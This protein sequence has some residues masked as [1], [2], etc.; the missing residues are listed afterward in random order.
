MA[1]RSELPS[2][3]GQAAGR[4]WVRVFTV[5]STAALAVGCGDG[6]N[7]P[8]KFGAV[9][10]TVYLPFE[11]SAALK[12]AVGATVRLS[13]GDFDTSTVTGDAG[14]FFFDQVPARTVRLVASLGTCLADTQVAVRVTEGDTTAADVTLSSSPSSNCFGLPF[15]GAAR[16]E[17]DPASNRAVLLYDAAYTS[18]DRSHPAIVVVD[19]TSGEG[20]TH[21]F[22][23]LDD[24]YDLV[25]VSGTEAVFNFK[26]ATGFGLRFFDVAAMTASRADVIFETDLSFQGGR[27]ALDDLHER[28]FVTVGNQPVF[29]PV[30]KVYALSLVTGLW[31]DADNDPADGDFAFDDDLVAGA[32]GWA[33]NIAFDPAAGEIL[34]GSRVVPFLQSPF[35]T[36]ISVSKWG[37]FD[38]DSNLTA[39]T[40]GVRKINMDPGEGFTGFA[41]EYWDFAGGIGVAAKSLS[42]RAGMVTYTSGGT[43]FTTKLV[44]ENTQ[45]VA[46]NQFLTIIPERQTWFTLIED[47]GRPQAVRKSIEERELSTLQRHN[48]YETRFLEDPPLVPRG[49][50]VNTQTQRLYVAYQNSPI[51]E[52]FELCRGTACGGPVM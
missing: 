44:E 35:L 39:P 49:F 52:V 33:Y 13:V 8:T 24:V 38:R 25:L 6:G 42:G 28:L 5:A 37:T 21:E 18:A 11:L 23:D 40:P 10:G 48:R 29:T 31:L 9:A 20:S 30:G 26:S 50:A 22:A 17:I 3:S 34:V 1:H 46:D 14:T 16:M 15:A 45:L 47:P 4:F 7:G 12:P 19:L 27:I 2:G 51:L 43:T 41:V 32:L 36:A